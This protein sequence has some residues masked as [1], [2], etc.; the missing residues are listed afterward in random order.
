[1]VILLSEKIF[2]VWPNFTVFAPRFVNFGSTCKG[3]AY[4][5]WS[6]LAKY[7]KRRCRKCEKFTTND[8]DEWND[9]DAHLDMNFEDFSHLF[10]LFTVRKGAKS[11]YIKY[12][13]SCRE[14]YVEDTISI[15]LFIKESCQFMK[16][17]WPILI[18]SCLS[19]CVNCSHFRHLLWKLWD[20]FYQT[21]YAWLLWQG[22]SYL[23]TFG[24]W[25]LR[26]STRVQTRV[27]LG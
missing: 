22:L 24:C 14:H 23:Y 18:T 11:F 7:L 21:W 5:V 16:F 2:D 9:L 15:S 6:K 3:H 17:G 27:K 25:S 20:N 13:K 4:Q 1:M 12:V 26:G 10:S 19:S 8:D